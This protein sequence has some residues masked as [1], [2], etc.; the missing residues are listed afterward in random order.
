[1]YADATRSATFQPSRASQQLMQKQE[2][3]WG[4]CE[5]DLSSLRELDVQ[6]AR[7]GAECCNAAQL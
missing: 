5:F 4:T 3:V 2:N 7:E 6:F 1:M